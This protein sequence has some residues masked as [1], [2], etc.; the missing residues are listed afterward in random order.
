L[1]TRRGG[2]LIFGG[3]TRLACKTHRQ[4]AY[5]C[6]PAAAPCGSAAVWPGGLLISG[7]RLPTDLPRSRMAH[8]SIESRPGDEP[9]PNPEEPE[10]ETEFGSRNSKLRLSNRNFNFNFSFNL[11]LARERAGW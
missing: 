2:E 5:V 9:T 8:L 11:K 1:Q 3:L 4:A 6:K 10:I 7:D